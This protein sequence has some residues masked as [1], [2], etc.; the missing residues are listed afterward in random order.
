ME[1]DVVDVYSN[2]DEYLGTGH[3]QDGT[4]AVRVFSFEQ[5]NPDI[6]FWKE[7]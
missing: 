6:E 7:K 1:G 2:Q 3:I 5:V 4:I